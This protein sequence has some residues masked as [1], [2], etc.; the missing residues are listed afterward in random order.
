MST[1]QYKKLILGMGVSGR[2]AAQYLIQQQEEFGIIAVD[3]NYCELKKNTKIA[4]L[5]KQGM[6]FFLDDQQILDTY[7]VKEIIVSPGVALSHPLIQQAQKKKIHISSEISFALRRLN[8]TCIGITGTNGKTTL[9]CLLEHIFRSCG[10][11]AH[12]VGNVG[13]SVSEYL[14]TADERD[15]LFV[16]LSSFQL[17]LID[18]HRFLDCAIITNLFADH[19][20]RYS[21]FEKYVQAKANIQFCIKEKKS[22]LLPKS[23]IEKVLPYITNKHFSLQ[24]MESCAGVSA[25]RALFSKK[26]N[27]VFLSRETMAFAYEVC[28]QN[29]ISEKKFFAAVQTFNGLS[30][31]IEF[32]TTMNSVHFYN[33]SKATNPMAVIHALNSLSGD[34]VLIVGGEDKG[35]DFSFWN[36]NRAFIRK[37][38]YIIAIGSSAKKIQA[39]VDVVRVICKKELHDAIETAYTLAKKKQNVLLSPG[40]SSYDMFANFEHRGNTFKDIVFSMKKRLEGNG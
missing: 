9:T 20:D 34:V 3:K 33:D 38:K 28:R 25:R 7:D 21:S 22:L 26:T 39:Q 23:C 32:V 11:K 10:R 19:L 1:K 14:L 35:L 8:N 18:K 40:C 29:T 31:R 13:K 16:E 6:L 37:V 17:E 5:E 30:H 27:K 36:N 24:P 4:L 2:A 15:I 12:S